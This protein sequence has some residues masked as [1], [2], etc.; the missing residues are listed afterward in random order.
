M[1]EGTSV[2]MEAVSDQISLKLPGIL[3]WLTLHD[4]AHTDKFT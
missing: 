2:M 4:Y 1:C 3:I